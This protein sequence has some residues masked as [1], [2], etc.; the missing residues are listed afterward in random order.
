[1]WDGAIQSSTQR[2]T[3]ALLHRSVL[4]EDALAF[5]KVSGA[6]AV[7]AALLLSTGDQGVLFAVPEATASTARHIVAALLIGDHAHM[8]AQGVVPK[9]EVR[10]LLRGDIVLVTQAISVSKSILDDLHIGKGQRLSDI[11]DVTTLSRYTA[12]KSSK[13][14]VF[15]AN[16]GWLRK[17]MGGRRF[18]AVV[19]DASHPSTFAQLPDLMRAASGCTSLRFAVSPPATDT[20]LTECGF[21][22]KLQLWMWDP[23]AKRDAETAVEMA[24]PKP[25]RT[26]ERVLWV[27]DSDDEAAKIL[28][29]TYKCLIA[30]ARASEGRVYPGLRLC[31]GIYNRLRQVAVPL[32]QLEQVSAN[33]WSGNLRK[34]LDDL[35][36]V[37][38]HGSVAWDTT[39]PQLVAALKAAYETLL[40]REETAKFWGVASNLE[41]FLASDAPFLRV[42]VGSE[43]EI[44]L[45]V[46]ALEAVVEGFSHAL[47]SSR[48]EFITGSKEARLVAEGDICPTV[49]LAPRTNGHRHLDVYPS[50]RIDELLYPHE[51]DVERSSQARLHSPW[52]SRI[53]D[54][55]RVQFLEPLGF[56]P[57]KSAK[58]RCVA[59]P[60]RVLVHQSNGHTVSLVCEAT[61][62]GE[63]D[64]D[65]LA[66][67]PGLDEFDGRAPAEYSSNGGA[68]GTTEIRFTNGDRHQYYEIQKVDIYLSETSSIQRHAPQ[69]VRPGWQVIAFVDGQYE[70]LFRRLA[71]SV[72]A[73]LPQGERVALEL[74]R[75]AKEHLAARADGKRALY[76]K[77]TS[78]GLTSS[79]GTF[80]SWF[81]DEQD[82]VI[83][84]QQF[85]DFRVLASEVEVYA[86]SG[87][88]LERTFRAVQ[89]ERG[90]NRAMGRT[91]RKFL[92]AVV[93][94][95]GYEEALSGARSLDAA[96]A[97]VLAAVEVLEVDS[98]V[99]VKRN[100]NGR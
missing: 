50:T 84:P 80:I 8:N 27:C 5:E 88:L 95:D 42:V 79:Y 47:L 17:A 60:P 35:E 64:I 59:Q 39:W 98:V 6:I 61:S 69:D 78:R 90:R 45:L 22:S 25:H 30:A 12:A 29:N 34:R 41:A 1:M 74:W 7:R 9:A 62:S 93:S 96:I 89:H 91:L 19:I 46:P 13:P 14:R 21:P 32:A 38:G 51:V 43:A 94:G 92:R 63:I 81:G 3:D 71:D 56:L 77:L 72:S 48:V 55:V 68:G 86:N 4:P 75:K 100:Q 85:D 76:D 82:D 33:S 87:Q 53:K 23:Q 11:W 31:W 83:A 49:L 52:T 36:S 73:R 54:E 67:A 2:I 57:L 99:E 10:P 65:A 28:A 97:D 18:G 15:L 26:A 40:R 66:S 44:A 20:V 70:G 24:D 37:N 16:P 58:P